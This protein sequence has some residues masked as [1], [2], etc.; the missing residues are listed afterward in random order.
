MSPNMIGALVGCIV[1]LAGFVF[2]RFAASR[3]ESK[4]V[5]PEP[6]KTAGILRIVAF[7][8]LVLFTVIGYFV[9]PMIVSGAAN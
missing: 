2:I 9:G 6:S 5:G 7:V 4:G 8:D 3:V 1:G